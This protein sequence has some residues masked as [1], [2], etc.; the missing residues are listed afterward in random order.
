M[1]GSLRIPFPPRFRLINAACRAI[2]M[3][4]SWT[5]KR[6]HSAHSHAS[7]VFQNCTKRIGSIG[8][9]AIDSAILKITRMQMLRFTFTVDKRSTKWSSSNDNVNYFLYIVTSKIT[10]SISL[11][12]PTTRFCEV[13]KWHEYIIVAR[14]CE[15]YFCS[16]IV[17]L[18]DNT[19][20]FYRQFQIIHVT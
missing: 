15:H 11:F 1:R 9:D 10:Q 19:L 6:T 20:L 14:R 18:F 4:Y 17:Y 5:C 16:L 3:P 7:R 8:A 2:G 12:S 13:S